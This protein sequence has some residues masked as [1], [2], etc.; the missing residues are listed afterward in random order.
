MLNGVRGLLLAGLLAVA[1][2]AGTRVVSPSGA[3]AYEVSL[4]PV[5]ERLALAWY[6]GGLAHAALWLRFADARGRPI[7]AAQPLTDGLREA[8]EPELQAVGDRL[9]VAWYEKDP[10]DGTLSAWLALIDERGNVLWRRQL[11]NAGQEGRSAIVRSAGEQL[12]ALWIE[13]APG[14]A[15]AVWMARLD[16][17]GNVTDPARRIAAAGD[18]TWL[19][20]AAVDAS[21]TLYVVYDAALGSRASEL[22]LLSVTGAQVT[23]TRLTPDDGI[24][25]TYPDIAIDGNRVAIA[26]TDSVRGAHAVYLAAGELSAWP[27]ETLP[28]IRAS[29][30]GDAGGAYLAWNGDRLALAWHE[31]AAG[32]TSVRARLY[33]S[34]GQPLGRTALLSGRAA[35]ALVP[36]I[37]RW[38]QGFAIAWNAFAFR[39]GDASVAVLTPWVPTVRGIR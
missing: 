32:R 8:Y 14:E 9:A 29:S 3:T 22:Q 31:T 5:G 23:A 6:G 4:A 1:G 12:L 7:G 10:A 37:R 20:N 34:R 30:G 24:D 36:D 35:R 19:L 28:A 26:W 17:A 18:S 21:D 11:S 16:A 25:S 15:P 33:S 38:R 39:S 13:R 27:P 2:C